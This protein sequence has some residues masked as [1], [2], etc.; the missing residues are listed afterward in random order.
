[1]QMEGWFQERSI[2]MD[3]Y[4]TTQSCRQGGTQHGESVKSPLCA[5]L[6]LLAQQILVYQTF[7]FPP[8]CKS[9]S[10]PLKS[11]TSI[12]NILLSLWLK[13]TLKG[14]LQ[15]FACLVAQAGKEFACSAGDPLV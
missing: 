13:M 10:S 6:S 7:A 4:S 9:P 5:P 12:L 14:G 8:P 15:S 2:T 11:Q 1:M 3:H